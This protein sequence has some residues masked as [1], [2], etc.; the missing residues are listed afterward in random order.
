MG[1]P[2]ASLSQGRKVAPEPLSM[3]MIISRL[4]P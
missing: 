1:E 3:V 4:P 2:M